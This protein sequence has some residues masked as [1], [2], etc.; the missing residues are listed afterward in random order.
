MSIIRID[1]PKGVQEGQTSVSPVSPQQDVGS[2][3]ISR[4]GAILLGYGAM[5]ASQSI[6]LATNEIRAGGN[7]ELATDIENVVKTAGIVTAVVA[8][9]GL[10]LIP[11][12]I[13]TGSTIVS[14]NLSMQRENRS[15]E[16]ERSM[17]GS[18]ITYMQGVGYE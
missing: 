17:Q 18:R 3:A 13:Q 15:R 6:Q 9:Q 8:T 1:M 12:A 11:L 7:E 4:K 10:A 2:P 14:R 16:F 5:V